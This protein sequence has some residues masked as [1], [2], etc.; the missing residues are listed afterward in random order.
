MT[1]KRHAISALMRCVVIVAARK[2]DKNARLNSNS[3]CIMPRREKHDFLKHTVTVYLKLRHLVPELVAQRLNRATE[4][5]DKRSLR[6]SVWQPGRSRLIAV[7]KAGQL[8]VQVLD[9][10]DVVLVEVGL[11]D[12]KGLYLD[13]PAGVLTGDRQCQGP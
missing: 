10:L 8:G 3:P 9:C 6:L 11:R 5:D 7:S 1:S 12:Q 2:F 4:V 13:Q